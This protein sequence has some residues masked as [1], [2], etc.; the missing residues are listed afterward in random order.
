[1]RVLLRI[2]TALGG[3]ALLSACGGQAVP[4]LPSPAPVP[5]T[6]SAPSASTPSA[7]VASASGSVAGS[8]GATSPSGGAEAGTVPDVVGM[9]L[10]DAEDALKSAG[11]GKVSHVDATGQGRRVIDSDNWVVRSQVPP[12]GTAVVPGT[13]V[14]LRVGK[15]SDGAGTGTVTAGTVPDVRCKERKGAKDALK[16]AGFEQLS[17]QDATGQGRRQIL[18]SSWIVVSQSVRAGSRPD[19]LTGIVLGVVKYGEPTGSSGCRS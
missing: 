8:A 15:P 14:T 4:Q 1:V 13:P 2:L 19:P 16:Q 5:A 12:A 9:R 10:P 7:G 6:S 18:T 3:V 11:Y 17:T